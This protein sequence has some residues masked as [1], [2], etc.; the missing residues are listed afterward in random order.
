MVRLNRKALWCFL[1]ALTGV[2]IRG[3]PSEGVELLGEM[4]GHQGGVEV[5]FEVL[6]RLVIEFFDRGF[7]EGT[8]HALDFRVGPGMIRLGGELLDAVLVTY[9]PNGQFES[10]FIW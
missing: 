1:P 6:M 10:L 8:L 2:F 9:A 4:I 3:K 5:L 7:F